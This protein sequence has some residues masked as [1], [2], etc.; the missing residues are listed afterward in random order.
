[1]NDNNL[2]KTYDN[3]GGAPKQRSLFNTPMPLSS[4][5][6]LHAYRQD[7]TADVDNFKEKCAKHILLDI[8]MKVLPF[9]DDYCKNNRGLIVNDLDKYLVSKNTSGLQYLKSSQESTK[10]P[11]LE[12]VVRSINNIATEY[13]EN[14]TDELKKNSD[15]GIDVPPEPIPDDEDSI[16]NQ[17]VDIKK[18][19]EYE[20]FIEKLKKKTINKIVTDISELLKDK[21]EEKDMTFNVKT[22]STAFTVAMEYITEWCM[23]NKNEANSSDDAIGLAIRESVL[24]DFDTIF[25]QRPVSLNEYATRLRFGKGIVINESSLGEV[26]ENFI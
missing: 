17:L 16:E 19:S 6:K 15:E 5:P 18:D 8:Y 23:K 7:I 26:V 13:Y 11:L 14:A 4:N 2:L 12:F 10:A 22:E 20:D 21:K 1:M 24:N 3:I 25:K 9:D